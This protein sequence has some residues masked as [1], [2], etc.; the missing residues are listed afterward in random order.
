MSRLA[1]TPPESTTVDLDWEAFAALYMHG[2]WDPTALPA[3]PCSSHAVD[4]KTMRSAY[5]ALISTSPTKDYTAVATLASYMEDCFSRKGYLPAFLPADH[6]A[7]PRVLWY[8]KQINRYHLKSMQQVL[9]TVIEIFQVPYV[10]VKL[11]GP[12]LGEDSKDA[13]HLDALRQKGLFPFKVVSEW[14][15]SSRPDIFQDETGWSQS[16]SA[17]S[18][19]LDDE[20]ALV[21]PDVNKDWRFA[22]SPFRQSF[23]FFVSVP[24]KG[25]N[26]ELIGAFSLA[27]IEKRGPVTATDMKKILDLSGMVSDVIQLSLNSAELSRRDQ[28]KRSTEYFLQHFLNDRERDNDDGADTLQASEGTQSNDG[29][30]ISHASEDYLRIYNFAAQTLQVSMDVSGVVIFDLSSFVLV[31]KLSH[32]MGK[33]VEEVHHARLIK[34]QSHGDRDEDDSAGDTTALLPPLPVLGSSEFLSPTELRHQ[35][36]DTETVST[37]CKFLTHTQ[38]GRQF[39]H[40]IPSVFAKLLPVEAKDPL[41]VPI[42][43]V[44]RQPFALICCYG[45]PG[46]YA[47]VLDQMIHTATQHI[48]AIGYMMMDVIMKHNV[49]LADRAKSSFISSMSHELR[50]PLHGILASAELLLDTNLDKLQQSYAQTI[51]SCGHGLLDLVNHV[52]DY[53]KLSSNST[54]V[55]KKKHVQLAECDLTTLIQEVC[56]S[57]FVG[58][59]SPSRLPDG[60][61]G[62]LGSVYDP[63]NASTGPT[64]DAGSI[65]LLIDIE[66]R[67]QGWNVLCDTGGLRRVLMNLIGN[68]LKFT[69]DGY[70]KVSLRKLYKSNNRMRVSFHVRDTG[71]G[72]SRSFLDQHLFQPFSQENPLGGGTGLGLSIV[73]EIVSSFDGGTVNVESTSGKGTDIVVSCELDA[74]SPTPTT[75]QPQLQVNHAYVVHL[76]GFTSSPAHEALR[77]VLSTYVTV[78]WGFDLSS[79][80]VSEE[81]L[82]HT[83]ASRSKEIFILNNHSDFLHKVLEQ[84]NSLQWRL[85]PIVTLTDIEDKGHATASCNKYHA[86][87]GTAEFLLKP[88]GPSRLE[89]V[90][91]QCINALE[92]LPGA[93][94]PHFSGDGSHFQVPAAIA[95]ITTSPVVKTPVSSREAMVAKL[96]KLQIVEEEAPILPPT[97]VQLTPIS[98]SDPHVVQELRSLDPIPNSPATC[99]GTT[100]TTTHDN[101]GNGVF[102][103]L[104]VD[105]NMVNRQVLRAYL[106]KLQISYVEAVDGCEA[107][108]FYGAYPPDYF[109]LILMDYTMP[110]IDGMVATRTIRKMEER[111]I[112]MDASCPRTAIY[113]LSG[114]STDDIMR[115]NLAAGADGYLVKPLSFKVLVPLVDSLRTST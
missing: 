42:M 58:Q 46:E 94:E 11:M 67:Q 1:S 55:K 113:M 115:M 80:D 88:A 10:S 6:I 3:Q 75:Y 114:T 2:D 40:S 20:Q 23:Q 68:S 110:N 37:I 66:K 33:S 72:I 14:T 106:K 60:A 86:Q 15:H 73:S 102:R 54:N 111:R 51:A 82:L 49:V 96:K 109:D 45:R 31:S 52:L 103:V 35:P 57:S 76:I 105:D 5:D 50:T 26:G 59:L 70:V 112:L 53:T 77:Q 61:N 44:E 89:I 71:I 48:R 4:R 21:V 36:M 56:D 78:W 74:P 69:S 79:K 12:K 28:L 65:E 90:L 41:F 16:L 7:L 30:Q 63:Q 47:F 99:L 62:G 38:L 64:N 9:R 108:A 81:E 84:R 8:S 32:T 27:D 18:L 104:F 13:D 29:S 87:G 34:H 17:H 39:R 91:R 24:L 85:P 98:A 22:K 95:S 83:M 19:Y 93:S 107:I 43:G 97:M 101:H 92:A 25:F 100:T